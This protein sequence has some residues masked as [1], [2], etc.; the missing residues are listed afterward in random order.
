MSFSPVKAM[1]VS[2]ENFLKLSEFSENFK[3]RAW[4]GHIAP[5]TTSENIEKIIQQAQL[6]ENK[7]NYK[8][9]MLHGEQRER[10][11]PDSDLVWISNY[12]R[13]SYSRIIK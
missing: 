7:G 2:M 10:F 11:E 5:K 8:K 13:D 3:K 9:G 1:K 12:H 6:N 4:G